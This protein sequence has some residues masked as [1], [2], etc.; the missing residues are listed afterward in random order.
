VEEERLPKNGLHWSQSR[1]GN[2]NYV[3]YGR[4]RFQQWRWENS[5]LWKI[6]RSNPSRENPKKSITEYRGLEDEGW[7]NTLRRQTDEGKKR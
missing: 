1:S 2:T 6:E 4:V 7:K 5:L 3:L